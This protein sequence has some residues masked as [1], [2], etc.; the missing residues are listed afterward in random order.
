MGGGAAPFRNDD[1]HRDAAASHRLRGTGIPDLR[2][3]R[4]RLASPAWAVA[5]TGRS[6]WLL[7]ADR[8][9][10]DR[11]V[12]HRWPTAGGGQIH[13]NPGLA[14]LFRIL[15]QRGRAGFYEGEVA[16]A[17]V[18]KSSALGGTMSMAD[19]ASYSGEWVTWRRRSITATRSR[20]CR[21][22]HR[23]G[24]RT[25]CST[26]SRAA[27]PCGRPGQTLASLGPANPEV[28]A[29]ARRGEETRL[30]RSLCLQRRSRISRG[31]ARPT[32]V[33]AVRRITV[34]RVN[35]DARVAA[36]CQWDAPTPPATRSCCRR[37]T[38]PATWWRG[39][40][41]C[42]TASVLVS[43]CP[44]TA[45]RCTTAAALFTLDPKSPNV[46]RA[47]QAPVQHAVGGIREAERAATDDGD[48][49]GRRHA[50]AG[51]CA[52]ARQRARS[53]CECPG[54]DRHGSFPS[55]AGPNVL[56]LES[57]LFTWWAPTK[58]MG[59]D[60]RSVDGSIM[61]GYQAIMFTADADAAGPSRAWRF[62]RAGSDHRKDGQAAGF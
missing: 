56:S 48:A 38:A 46:D 57:P 23:R 32:A 30:R 8:S 9:R 15:Q 27:C 34:R 60:V 24:P 25:R 42:S 47:G 33:E 55:C 37:R 22:P 29:L 39:S 28:L 17:I 62:Y 50:G 41:A 40:T 21:R 49:D 18:A 61:G 16:S 36:G 45:S 35:P 12:V 11:H 44:A 7:H 54:R 14:K 31:A 13:R 51:Y 59:H 52:G 1:V 5:D 19:L 3:H 53:W 10:F 20:R 6:P 58:A 2:T 4:I 26:S 43:L